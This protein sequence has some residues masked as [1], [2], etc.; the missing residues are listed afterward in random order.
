MRR[1]VEISGDAIRDM[2]E[3]YDFIAGKDGAAIA[4]NVITAF[5][6]RI[7]AL[8]Q[9]AERG[10]YPKELLA[11]DVKDYRELHYKPYRII[12]Q[13]ENARVVVYCVFDGRRDLG[14]LLQRRLG[15]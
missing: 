3:I 12:Y 11:M 8:D 7:A 2:Q 5:E 6:E 10:N 1:N 9:L 4:D 14:P 13:V 15:I